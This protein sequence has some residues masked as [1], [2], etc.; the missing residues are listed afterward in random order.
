VWITKIDRL[1]NGGNN[2]GFVRFMP[3]NEN[4]ETSLLPKIKN[5]KFLILNLAEIACQNTK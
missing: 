4:D 5:K 3:R 1:L 2:R